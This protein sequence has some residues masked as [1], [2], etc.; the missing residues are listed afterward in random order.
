MTDVSD[1]SADQADFFASSGELKHVAE[2]CNAL[3][4]R[5]LH[6]LATQGP[7]QIALLRR[8]LKGLSHHIRR[9]AYFLAS[10]DSPISVDVH[11]ASWQARQAAKCPGSQT[12]AA[13]TS[14][15]FYRHA[16]PGLVVP[17]RVTELDRQ[18]IELD[19]VDRVDKHAQQMHINK[20]GWFAFSGAP[21]EIREMAGESWVLKPTKTIMTAACCGHTWNHKGRSLPRALALREML[22]S[23]TINW[24]HFYL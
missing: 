9:A 13:K 16:T 17:V 4:E 6:Y 10:N 11:N 12:D 3:Y 1:T 15:W 22:L 24:R 19:S 7:S 21:V 8:R 14:D 2:L 23:T 5:E 18:H 20:Y